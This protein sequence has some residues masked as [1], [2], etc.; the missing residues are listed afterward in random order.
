VT[1]TLTVHIHLFGLS[2]MSVYLEAHRFYTIRCTLRK[3]LRRRGYTLPVDVE[4]ETPERVEQL[5][6]S[7][8]LPD[9]DGGSVTDAELY[10]MS[11]YAIKG[12]DVLAVFFPNVTIHTNLGIAPIRSYVST[13]KE[14]GCSSAIIVVCGSLT[15]P[16]VSMLRELEGQNLFITAFNECELLVDIYEHEKVPLHEPL[17][18]ADKAAVLAQWKL[19]GRQ[20]PE[21]QRHD[22]MARYLGLKVGDVVRIRRVSPTTGFDLYYRIVVNSEDF[23]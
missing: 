2:L 19:T 20:L 22:P 17:S 13:M 18:A 4:S 7:S 16:A 21:M 5:Y 12:D 3:M 9:M 14:R 10:Y 1:T 8:L 23:N 15:S 11:F 6:L